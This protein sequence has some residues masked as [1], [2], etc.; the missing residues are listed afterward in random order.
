[1]TARR[2]V[3]ALV[4]CAS[5]AIGALAVTGPAEATSDRVPRAQLAKVRQATDRYH[6]VAAAKADGYDL[7][8]QCFDD[9]EMG[10]MGYHYLK[11]VD[12]VLNPL[13]PEAMVYEPTAHGLKLVAVEYI[14][15]MDLSNTPPRVLGRDLHENAALHLW[16]LHAWIWKANPAGMFADYNPRVRSCTAS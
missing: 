7:L 11:G 14:V 2:I 10:G 6:S 4:A 12:A 5:V 8:D 15:P 1:V 13:E 16:V 3:V 9:A